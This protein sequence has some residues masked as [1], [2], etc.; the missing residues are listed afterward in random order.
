MGIKT[1]IERS[2]KQSEPSIPWIKTLIITIL[3]L[4]V[5]GDIIG[6]IVGYNP[7]IF[8]DNEQLF[9]CGDAD[10]RETVFYV[11]KGGTIVSIVG[12]LYL[13]GLFVDKLSSSEFFKICGC[14]MYTVAL[15]SDIM[16][17]QFCFEYLAQIDDFCKQTAFA[18]MAYI[19]AIT[20]CVFA[21]APFAFVFVVHIYACIAR[22]RRRNAKQKSTSM[23]NDRSRL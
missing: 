21:G 20:K 16:C 7:L 10:L 23:V 6:M 17:S 15:P 22:H 11:L 1:A 14:V 8:G 5:F 12:E 13:I 4:F 9:S 18:N 3:T 19:F 2:R